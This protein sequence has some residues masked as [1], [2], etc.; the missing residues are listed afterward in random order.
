MEKELV[1]KLS[2]IVSRPGMFMINKV[3]DFHVF[4]QGV[5]ISKEYLNLSNKIDEEFSQF[6]LKLSPNPNDEIRWYRIIRFQSSTDIHSLDL[7][8]EYFI[9]YLN[10]K[11]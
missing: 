9:K 1:D 5:S 10:E 6:L 2:F 7:L 11:S 3:E 8:K 4:L